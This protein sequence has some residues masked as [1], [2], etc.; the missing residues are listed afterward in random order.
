MITLLMALFMVLFSISSVN[1]SK[2][3]ALQQSLQDAFSGKVLPGGEAISEQRQRHGQVARVRGRSRR[4]RR[5]SR[6]RAARDQPSPSQAPRRRAGGAS[7]QLKREID[8]YARDARARRQVETQHQRSAGWSCGCS[9]TSVLFDS[10]AGG[11]QAAGHC[12]CSARSASCSTSTRRHQIIVEGHTDNVP[13]RGVAVPDQLGAV[14]GARLGGR[15]LP[16]RARRRPA[17]AP[18]RGGLRRTSIRRLQRHRRRALAQPPRRDRAA[19]ADR[20]HR[21]VRQRLETPWRRDQ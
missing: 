10:G 2:F 15:A 12:R 1:M 5:S 16:D 19:S 20:D 6:D 7:Q 13:I 9:P 21:V 3:E 8:A 18:R 4:S 14:D 17:P 11:A